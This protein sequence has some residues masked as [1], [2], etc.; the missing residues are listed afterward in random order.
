MDSLTQATLGAAVGH[1]CWNKKIGNKALLLGA[2]GGTIPDLDIILYPFL[3]DIQ[4]LYWHRGESHS[5]WFVL[6]GSLVT[7][8]LL[9]RYFKGGKIPFHSA[10]LGALLI[11]GTHILIDYFTVYGTQLLA[12]FS[13][14]AFALGNFFII[15]PLFTLP[16]LLGCA[17][18]AISKPPLGARANVAGLTLATCYM[19]WSFSAQIIADQTFRLALSKENTHINRQ[20]TTAGPFTTFLWRHVAETDD[21]FFLGYWSIFDSPNKTIQFYHIPRRADLVE[22]ISETGTFA[23]V[24]WFSQGWWYAVEDGNNLVKVVDLRFGAI[25]SAH[26]HSHREWDWPFAWKFD[27]QTPQDKSLLSVLPDVDAP[28]HTLG[29]LAGRIMG[30]ENWYPTSVGITIGAT[31]TPESSAGHGAK[32][33]KPLL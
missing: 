25:P 7:G 15:D 18:A 14:T 29:L 2:I 5:I 11:Y 24:K 16:L 1:L 9:S 4:R 19:V 26:G 10:V 22:K 21:G 31:I 32:G 17:V 8:W 13:R 28:L 27:L 6:F 23:V 30:G 20:R 33:Q 12:P 3:D